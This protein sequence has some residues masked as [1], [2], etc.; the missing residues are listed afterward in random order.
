MHKQLSC[1]KKLLICSLAATVAVSALAKNNAEPYV[2]SEN[3][4]IPAIPGDPFGDFRITGINRE[5]MH[6]TIYGS[7]EN[8]SDAVNKKSPYSMS[9]NGKWKFKL[10]P[11]MKSVPEDFMKVNYDDANW[12]KI[13]VPSCWQMDETVE[14]WAYYTNTAYIFDADPP[15]LPAKNTTGCYRLQV[16][17][18]EDWMDRD[19]RL[20]F[21]GVESA[22]QLWVNGEMA[23]YGEDSRLPSEFAI[24]NLLH[25]GANTIAVKVARFSTGTYLEGQ[26]VWH[27]SGI[28][29]NVDLVARPKVHLRDWCITTK[30][31]RNYDNATLNASVFLETRALPRTPTSNRPRY[32]PGGYR[33]SL[34]LVDANG[35]II[36]Q[37]DKRGFATNTGMYGGGGE[38]RESA[39]FTVQVKSPLK[40]SPEHPNLYKLFIY[41]H[42]GNDRVVE[43]QC[44]N[45]GFRQVEIK[46]RQVLLNGT[47]FTVRGVNRHDVSAKHAFAVTEEEMRADIALMKK[48]NFNAVRTCHYPNNERW[49]ELCDE[50][51]IALVG[52]TNVE[53]HPISGQLSRMSEWAPIYLERAQRMVLRDRNHPSILIW[54]LGNESGV[55]AAH[56]AMSSWIHY[57]DPTRL[58]QYEGGNPGPNISDLQVP[59]YPRV[60]D[61]RNRAQNAND[62]RPVIMCEYAYAKGNSTGNFFKYWDVI[63]EFPSLQ[64]GFF[65]DWSDKALYG[66]CIADG[67]KHLGYG[68]D[69][70]ENLDYHRTGGQHPTQVLNGIVA[71]DLTPHPGAEEVRVCQAP[72]SSSLVKNDAD[73]SSAVVRVNNEF[74]DINLNEIKL[75]WTYTH[76]GEVLVNS[77]RNEMTLPATEPGKY[78]DITLT[79]NRQA[80]QH[81]PMEEILNL[82]FYQGENEITR[83]QYIFNDKDATCTNVVNGGKQ[84]VALSPVETNDSL[85]IGDFTWSKK[86]GKLVSIKS[87]GKELLD[88]PADQIFYRAPID[89]DL[90]MDNGGA[91][92][93]DWRQLY[94]PQ[95]NLL[96][97]KYAKADNGSYQVTVNSTVQGINTE[98]NWYV[99]GK[100]SLDFSQKISFTQDKVRTIARVGMMFPFAENIYED[101][102]YYGRGPH[103][104]YPDRQVSS[105]VGLYNSKIADMLEM[106]YLIPSENGSR[107]EIRHA[108][109]S[110]AEDTLKIVRAKVAYGQKQAQTVSAMPSRNPQMSQVKISD[111]LR[112]SALPVSPITLKDT[113][114]SWELKPEKKTW[115]IID[116][117]HMGVG[118]DD[119]WTPSVHQ[120]YMLRPGSYQWGASLQFGT[121]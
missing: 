90:I 65:W 42:D 87:N 36:A 16:N 95:E 98:V 56:A 121:K 5:T 33:T 116:G 104:N 103:E 61:L 14:D 31:D 67:Q 35:Q 51:G 12:Y 30:F 66:T 37:T 29:R 97:F 27:M 114:H 9:L 73:K 69:L 58:V 55:G 19:I 54:S 79:Y 44:Q 25:P 13:T 115:L 20:T 101:V 92:A 117:F 21:R 59:M 64:G 75:K 68:N 8:E 94:H 52:E 77:N 57:T 85:T 100:D 60:G 84:A 39:N 83:M 1:V 11:N 49:Y 96:Q 81:K 47:P 108:T 38:E 41:L 22:F 119:G 3:K 88:A 53:T 10:Y 93:N 15:L 2:P 34:K 91:Y 45:V 17:I 6:T 105:L 110:G 112:F 72:I 63:R 26:D 40:W 89:N 23:G 118:G 99:L 113:A 86:T 24:T 82:Y 106:S 120:E 48:L 4:C 62:P 111:T 32:Y 76:D 7:Y 46:N 28:Y 71:G 80:N 18:P 78:A 102:K 50:M 74:H 43:V 70:G 107:G 109:F